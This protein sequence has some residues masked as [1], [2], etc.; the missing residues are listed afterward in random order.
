MENLADKGTGDQYTAA[1]FN[2]NQNEREN[3][4]TDSGQ[5]LPG[6]NYQLSR[7]M[8]INA[9]G[10]D[11]YGVTGGPTA[12]IASSLGSLR[13][14][15][16]YYQGQRVRGRVPTTNGSSPTINVGAVGVVSILKE[17]GVTA[18]GGGEMTTGA[19]FEL[20]YDTTAGAFLLKAA[21][22]DATKTSKGILFLGDQRIILS[23]NGVD[24]N[25]D[26][27]FSIGR[28]TFDDG[29]GQA[30]SNA[31]TKQLDATFVAGNNQGML[32]TG[33]KA[34][35][36][37]YKCFAIYNP[38]NGLTDYLASTSAISPTLPSGYTKKRRIGAIRTDDSNNIIGFIQQEKLFRYKDRILDWNANPGTTNAVLAVLTVPL[39]VITN[40]M[41]NLS[42]ATAAPQ[43]IIFTDPAE[44][45]SVPSTLNKTLVSNGGTTRQAEILVRTNTSS[46]VRFRATNGVASV[47]RIQ[48]LG[49]IDETLE[50]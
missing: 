30:I 50:D 46:Q 19:D 20:R 48:T 26:I 13:S 22:P 5:S 4:V 32:D 38:T 29:S 27:D 12:Y 35:D 37:S 28:F 14:P 9:G 47:F 33:T 49:Y 11:Y 25:N 15:P 44:N 36:T 10:A 3:A 6:D 2:V 31:Y 21:S 18:L 41:L 1:E 40:T 17:D 23:N 43:E 16:A 42:Y 8:S 39:G 45:D 24:P 34:V 7:A